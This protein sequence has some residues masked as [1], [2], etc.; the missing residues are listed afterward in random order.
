MRTT[1]RRSPTSRRLSTMPS[2]SSTTC[3]K[4]PAKPAFPPPCASRKKYPERANPKKTPA[5]WPAFSVAS[6]PGLRQYLE[7]RATTCAVVCATG[8]VRSS[9]KRASIQIAG[10][11]HHQPR[12]RARTVHAVPETV[13]RICLPSA[14]GFGGKL[15]CGSFAINS[16]PHRRAVKISRGVKDQYSRRTVDLAA[17]KPVQP[18][19]CPRATGG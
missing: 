14:T 3:K 11:I 5:T 17:G 15:E 10:G 7:H 2:R 4:K 19:L 9:N 16:A 6:P 1:N 18:R 8:Y 13:Q 12:I